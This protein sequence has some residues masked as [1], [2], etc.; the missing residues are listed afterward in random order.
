MGEIVKEGPVERL[1]LT[2]FGA[3]VLMLMNKNGM[4]YQR[5]LLEALEAAGY[6][7]GQTRLSNWMHGRHAVDTEFP[8]QVART[9]NLDDR[10]RL[11]LAEAYAYGQKKSARQS[12][13]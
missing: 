9:L 6:A 2:K 1:R 12:S 10:D 7:V 8:E 3:T 13:E 11:A 5:E 4:R